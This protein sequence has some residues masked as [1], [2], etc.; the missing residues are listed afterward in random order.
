MSLLLRAVA[1]SSATRQGVY[2]C[3]YVALA[4]REDCEL[5]TADDKLAKKLQPAFPFILPLSALP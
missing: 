4:E 5:V 1:I 3:V 2:D